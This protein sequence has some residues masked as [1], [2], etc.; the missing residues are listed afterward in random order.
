MNEF[1]LKIHFLKKKKK[2]IG[3][4][5]NILF[6]IIAQRYIL[7]VTNSFVLIIAFE[8]SNNVLQGITRLARVFLQ[9]GENNMKRSV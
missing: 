3:I 8:I 4:I 7:R 5:H 6:N 2:R 1:T 9:R